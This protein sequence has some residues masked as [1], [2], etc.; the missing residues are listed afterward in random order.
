MA[1]RGTSSCEFSGGLGAGP[2]RLLST[3]AARLAEDEGYPRFITTQASV[4]LNRPAAIAAGWGL[5]GETKCSLVC[6][7]HP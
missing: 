5:L 4:L 6:W 2:A 3:P 7:T 1:V